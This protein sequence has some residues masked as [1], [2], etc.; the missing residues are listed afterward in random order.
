MYAYMHC[1]NLSHLSIFAHARTLHRCVASALLDVVSPF[2]T[3]GEDGNPGDD[4]WSE[5]DQT[6]V[7]IIEI[8]F[9]AMCVSL[10]VLFLFYTCKAVVCVGRIIF[11]SM[12]GSGAGAGSS[13][14]SGSA[15]TSS[16]ARNE[17]R[18]SGR[19]GRSR[20][21][22]DA[23]GRGMGGRAT[24]AGAEVRLSMSNYMHTGTTVLPSGSA[25]PRDYARNST[26][27][28]IVNGGTIVAP[29]GGMAIRAAAPA[30]TAPTP[31]FL[32]PPP[33]NPRANV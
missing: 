14:A 16:S 12:T 2:S 32:P 7:W 29:P 18:R 24:G 33:Y 26:L 15:I 10:M 9:I 13:A 23:S 22:S 5:D 17:R 3:G 30:K 25:V 21:S 31:P 11:D 20:R 19:S 1:M 4:I 27:P 6:F 28:S 8:L